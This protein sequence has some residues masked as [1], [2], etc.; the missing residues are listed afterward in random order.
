MS[1]SWGAVHKAALANNGMVFVFSNSQY[2]TVKFGVMKDS[3]KICGRIEV[4]VNGQKGP[5]RNGRDLFGF[6]VINNPQG[7]YKLIPAGT[8]NEDSSSFYW[9]CVTARDTATYWESYGCAYYMLHDFAPI[10]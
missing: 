1:D 2:C 10:E 9:R 5:N 3:S 4:D 7:S 6:A 8:P